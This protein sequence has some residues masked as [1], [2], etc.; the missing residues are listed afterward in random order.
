MYAKN[1]CRRNADNWFKMYADEH[2][3]I[4]RDMFEWIQA[5]PGDY[6]FD[7]GSGCGT[8]LRYLEAH[9]NASGL[10]IDISRTSVTWANRQSARSTSCWADGTDLAWLP[11]DCFDHV[12]SFGALG[13]VYV[14][15]ESY[16]EG[17][18]CD[19]VDELCRITKNGGYLFLGGMLKEPPRSYYRE[20]VHT[21]Q[22][23]WGPLDLRFISEWDLHTKYLRSVKH[24]GK[25]YH[26]RVGQRYWGPGKNYFKAPPS[27]VYT[28]II[29]LL[30]KGST[31][32][33][34]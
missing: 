11:T 3:I 20:C 7:W 17:L 33:Q 12:V 19:I 14:S 1:N 23:K 34:P 31:K 28:A 18:L 15:R 8:K 27:K 29:R 6:V 25:M 13:Y 2:E 26:V 22:K 4:A 30:D 9:F 32:R 10:G 5:K 24:D 21:L 16:G